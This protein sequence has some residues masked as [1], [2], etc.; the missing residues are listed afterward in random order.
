MS[1][2]IGVSPTNVGH[3]YNHQVI[4]YFMIFVVA[5]GSAFVCYI[6]TGLGV[7]QNPFDSLTVQPAIG[8]AIS[9]IWQRS[10]RACLIRLTVFQ[11]RRPLLSMPLFGV[12]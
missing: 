8:V 2:V 6:S 9:P 10:W 3:L 12:L 11:S 5:A 1:D 4:S 7:A